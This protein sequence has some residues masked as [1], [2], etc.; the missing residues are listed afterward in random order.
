MDALGRCGF[1]GIGAAIAGRCSG[2]GRSVTGAD[3]KPVFP[4]S[5]KA[6]LIV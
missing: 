5:V 3:F 2:L 4:I 1:P 6:L